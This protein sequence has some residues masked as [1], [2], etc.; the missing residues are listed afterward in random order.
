M[1]LSLR[2]FALLALCLGGAHSQAAEPVRIAVAANLL[3]TMEAIAKTYESQSGNKV[4]IVGGSSGAFFE[5]IQRGAPFDLFYSADAE[6]PEKLEKAGS[7]SAARTYACGRLALWV[8]DA[9]ADLKNLPAGKISVAQPDTA[10]YG[11]AAIQALT[12]SGQLDAVKDRIVYG[13]DIG[14]AFQFIKSHNTPSGFVAL[15]QL[16]AANVAE[17]QYSQVDADLYE[18][19]VQKR[20][21]L[22]KGERKAAADAFVSYFDAQQDTLKAAGYALPGE[23]GCAAE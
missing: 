21:V 22:A 14:Q 10:P 12:K 3:P 20:V 9:K 2:P 15:S 13:Q 6:R 11:K 4:E 18:P 5:Q 23:A 16:K 1:R 8:P 17:T 7:G 19:L